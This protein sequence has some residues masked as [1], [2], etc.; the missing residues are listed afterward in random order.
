VGGAEEGE[1]AAADNNRDGDNT[2]VL[3][4]NLTGTA[5]QRHLEQSPLALLAQSYRNVRIV[6]LLHNPEEQRRRNSD[7]SS[8]SLLLDS[9]LATL[10]SLVADG[11][12][13]RYGVVSNGLCL[14][15]EHPLH[16][17]I[18]AVI[19]AAMSFGGYQITQLPA[20]ALE[21]AGIRVARELAAR[22]TPKRPESWAPHQVYA[23]RPL[24]CYP[25]RGAGTG[26]PFVLADLL[27]PEFTGTGSALKAP[28]LSSSAAA[29]APPPQLHWTNEMP[30]SPPPAYEQALK[31]SMQHF[32]ADELVQ[33][34]LEGKALTGEQR[35]TLD[36]CKLLQSLFHDLDAGLH[37]QRSLAAHDEYLYKTVIPLIHDTFESYDEDTAQVLERF[38]AAYTIAVRHAVAK[39]TRALLRGGEG[40]ASTGGAR[41]GAEAVA[42]IPTSSVPAYDIP[43][44]MRLQE[45][46]LRFLLGEPAISKVIVGATEVDQVVENVGIVER[47][48]AQSQQG[49]EPEE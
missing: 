49:P 25:D 15:Q 14:P 43:D 22:I 31:L 45:F 24:A 35:E 7:Q 17:P 10:E 48:A 23:M 6:P 38:F 9:A 11:A 2:L 28:A 20:N 47:W 32:D 46:G 33:A 16:L 29:H 3:V 36:G 21:T 18:D 42:S 4:H 39:N 1:G 13:A 37:K 5:I 8:S 41:A 40:A 44:E 26:H 19:D 30:D 34:K 12:V 27:I